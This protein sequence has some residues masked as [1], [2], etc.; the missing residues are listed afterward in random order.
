MRHATLCEL[1]IL[2]ISFF[3]ACGFAN[4]TAERKQT[5]DIDPHW[6][7][8]NNR[9]TRENYPTITQ[10]FGFSNTNFAGTASG[11]IGGQIW[12]SST[13]ATYATPIDTATFDKPLSASGTLA[14]TKTTAGSGVM[15]GWFN[16]DFP[17]GSR[18]LNS[19]MFD[20]DG[21][22]GGVRIF[23]RVI[24]AHNREAGGQILNPGGKFKDFLIKSDGSKHTWAA[25]Y[26]PKS[27]KI[28]VNF[29]HLT[30]LV[31]TLP[32]EVRADGVMLDRFGIING[33]KSGGS[34]KL[35]LDDL[36]LGDHKFDFTT[37]PHWEGVGNHITFDDHELAHDQNFG[38]SNTSFACGNKGEIGGIIWRTENS[39][40]WYADNVGSLNLDQPLTA[41][42]KITLKVGAPDSGIYF[43]W[44]NRSAAK[45]NPTDFKNFLGAHI[46]GPSRIGHYFAPILANA[47]GNRIQIKHAAV[48]I[49][50]GKSHTFLIAYKP[51]PDGSGQMS[52]TLDGQT[53]TVQISAQ[54]RKAGATFDRFGFLTSR[55]GGS[56]VKIYVD[57]LEYTAA[58]P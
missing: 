13:P 14:I 37:D 44:F 3:A 28:T 12:R 23:L 51:N 10:D 39:L 18:P 32:P 22:N 8:L 31:I 45:Q 48:L 43:G 11:E 54:A 16:H 7:A 41:S 26:D 34:L 6:D 29:D 46:E 30:P 24:T 47:D 20:I 4:D 21:E 27:G 17:P 25:N 40:S 33:Q 55:V 1:T 15:F 56:E 36:T 50:D 58:K 49:P 35:Y 19:I 42:G 2:T 57:D 52:T 53:T 38:F 9:L 5:F